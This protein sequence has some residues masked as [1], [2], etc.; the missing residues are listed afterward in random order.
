MSK[1]FKT[2][3]DA[4]FD[5]DDQPRKTSESKRMITCPQCYRD[6]FP[7]TRFCGY[8]GCG[9]A[10]EFVEPPICPKCKKTFSVDTVFC[11][12]DG[13]K[14]VSPEQM[15]PKCVRC[16]KTYTDGTKF[17]P[18][19]GGKVIAEALRTGMDFDSAK[20]LI[21]ENIDKGK[22]LLANR[23]KK[24][25]LRIVLGVSVFVIMI[26]LIATVGGSSPEKDGIKAA[27]KGCDCAK[28]YQKLPESFDFKKAQAKADRCLQTAD[29]Y[30]DKLRRKYATNQE[31]VEKFDFAYENYIIYE[32]KYGIH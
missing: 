24:A 19:D 32:C 28:E 8:C 9:F 7:G 20:E 3:S 12:Q 16:G 11:S 18:K 13:T 17:C 4:I 29:E 1:N 6:S 21:I 15:I 5:T 23:S 31:K 10:K 30:R 25:S 22:R 27:K 14:L 2:I 26:A